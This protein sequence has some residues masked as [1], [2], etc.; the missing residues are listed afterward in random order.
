MKG[1]IV[2]GIAAVALTGCTVTGP[3]AT[4]SVPAPTHTPTA[5]QTSTPS[6]TPSAEPTATPKPQPHTSKPVPTPAEGTVIAGDIGELPQ[7]FMLPDEGRVA[8]DMDSGFQTT[9]FK[10][11]CLDTAPLQ[12]LK[13]SRIKM[14]SGPEYGQTNGLL[15][16][17]DAASATAFVD[18]V[19]AAYTRCPAQGGRDDE[20]FRTKQAIDSSV[21]GLGEQGV[22]FGTWSEWN[23]E[24]TDTWVESP[25]GDITYFVRKGKF[26]ALSSEG[27]EY[28][29][30]TL[31]NTGLTNRVDTHIKQILA[32]V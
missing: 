20:E 9:T 22:R 19:L 16:F 13:A 23:R 8:D 11:S 21:K 27:A 29:G 31:Q 26:V 10:V 6:P 28:V 32:Q 5:R 4:P 17:A 2:A 7:G 1:I 15:V 3:V 12:K 25:G 30:N 18:Q 24:R 14:A